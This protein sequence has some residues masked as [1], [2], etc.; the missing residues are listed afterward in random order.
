MMKS[1]SYYIV[2]LLFFAILCSACVSFFMRPPIEM[3][4]LAPQMIPHNLKAISSQ[5]IATKPAIEPTPT[6]L[7][8]STPTPQPQPRSQSIVPPIA[9]ATTETNPYGGLTVNDLVVRTYGAGELKF[10]EELGTN[11]IFTRQ[12]FSYKSDGLTVYGFMNI[13]HEAKE[14]ALPIIMV[15]HGHV[16][17]A[18]YQVLTYTTEQA[19]ELARAGYIVIHPNF[20]NFP[21]SDYGP[22]EMRIG[23][24]IDVLNLAALIRKEAGNPGPLKHVDPYMMGMW[25]HSMGGGIALRALVVDPYIK[26]AV[27]YASMSGDEQLNHDKLVEFGGPWGGNWPPGQEPSEKELLQISPINHLWRINTAI[28]IHHGTLDP[29]P[30]AWAEDLCTQLETQRKAVECFTY[31]NA[32]HFFADD[33]K[34]MFNHRTAQFFD[35]YLK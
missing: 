18:Y 19:D 8:T 23:Y 12:L 14:E 32:T 11:R 21:P 9:L 28:S 3:H 29:L 6:A 10:H 17:P 1:T 35:Q 33:D 20:R 34:M 31:F 22:N 7:P 24:A 25:G 13:P 26:A 16:D 4:T 27:L 30:V 5:P 15:L 2:T